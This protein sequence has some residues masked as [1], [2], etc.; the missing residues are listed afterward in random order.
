MLTLESQYYTHDI[1]LLLVCQHRFSNGQLVRT[2]CPCYVLRYPG[3]D[4]GC[5]WNCSKTKE[6][7]GDK[8]KIKMRR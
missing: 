2:V 8:T 4:I 7:N 5:F 1:P 3:D 6:K